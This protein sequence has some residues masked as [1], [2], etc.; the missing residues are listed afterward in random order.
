M[1]VTVEIG[2]PVFVIEMPILA[3]GLWKC[4]KYGAS[5][6]WIRIC[7]RNSYTSSGQYPVFC[8]VSL[9]RNS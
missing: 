1:F 3:R 9:S 8:C 5:K 2:N 7:H 4:T 6:S